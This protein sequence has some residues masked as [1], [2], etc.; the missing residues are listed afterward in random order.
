MRIVRAKI[1]VKKSILDQKGAIL[2]QIVKEASKFTDSSHCSHCFFSCGF[3]A[4][5][6]VPNVA[7]GPGED[8]SE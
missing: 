2:T 7:L 8:A 3:D 1:L 4:M 6:G 5:F